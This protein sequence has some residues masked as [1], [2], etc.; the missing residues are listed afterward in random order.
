MSP[1][2]GSVSYSEGHSFSMVNE[3]EIRS[4][5]DLNADHLSTTEVLSYF[6]ANYGLDEKS[7]F[8]VISSY[9]QSL[10]DS[11]KRLN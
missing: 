1:L 4:F 9:F 6:K 3:L 7:S 11:K 8:K 10:Q 2:T 5:L